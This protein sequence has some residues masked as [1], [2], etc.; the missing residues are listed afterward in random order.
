MRITRY[1]IRE[2][3]APFLVGTTFL[4]VI[5]SAYASASYLTDVANDMLQPGI[6]AYLI[7]LKLMTVLDVIL[8]SALYF[9]V[10]FGLFR[11]YRDA[12]IVAFMAAGFS[13]WQ[14]LRSVFYFSLIVALIVGLASNVGRPWAFRI[15]YALKA[16]AMAELDIKKIQ[17]G[18]FH[19]LKRSNQVLFAETIDAVNGRL[20]DIYM[21]TDAGSGMIRV[22]TAQ[23][24]QLPQSD[25]ANI[26]PVTFEKGYIYLLD[27]QGS[28]DRVI[29]FGNLTLPLVGGVAPVGYKRKAAYT[30]E[31]AHS[32][33]AG[34]IAEFQWRLAT[35]LTSI[36]LAL[37]GVPL[38]Y[39]SPGQGRHMRIILAIIVYALLFNLF[40]VAHS[41]VDQAQVPAFPGIWWFYL[42]PLALLWFLLRR[43]VSV[44]RIR[45]R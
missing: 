25:A 41:L 10:I 35:P 44:M 37:L 43:P 16:R 11:L 26:L 27:D 28:K 8:P 7:F 17:A 14:L 39:T 31:L 21:Q 42:L 4:A 1:I 2:I 23:S 40:G 19:E 30:Y 29:E 22:I 32:D 45:D 36:L 38:S 18:R 15:N 24:L 34:D 13:E 20:H 9:S 12:E 5:F 33:N 3:T 6:I